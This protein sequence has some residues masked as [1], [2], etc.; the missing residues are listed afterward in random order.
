MGVLPCFYHP[1]GGQVHPALLNL[2]RM[3]HPHTREAIACCIYQTLVA[4]GI[5]EEKVISKELLQRAKRK[6]GLSLDWRS[7]NRSVRKVELSTLSF[8][9]MGRTAS[10]TE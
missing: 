9:K 2:Q 1:P 3:E 4:W 6:C 5:G 7:Q 10:S 8:E